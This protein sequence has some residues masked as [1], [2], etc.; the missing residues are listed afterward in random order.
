[1]YSFSFLL[2]DC[3]KIGQNSTDGNKP[4]FFNHIAVQY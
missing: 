4:G 3:Y 1:M 2:A